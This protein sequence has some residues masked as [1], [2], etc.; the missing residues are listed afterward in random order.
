M[1]DIFDICVVNLDLGS[2]LLVAPGKV[3]AK[4]ESEKKVKY[5]HPC[6]GR[7]WHF[8]LIVLPANIIPGIE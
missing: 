7:R 1:T 2:Y 3:L 6:L 8:T 5:L 4:V